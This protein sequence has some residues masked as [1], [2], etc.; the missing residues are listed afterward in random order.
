MKRFKQIRENINEISRSMTPMKNKFGAR[1]I[2]AKKMD[3]YK[4]FAKSKNIDD[5]SIR[6]AMANPNAGESKKMMKNKD[7][8]KAMKMYKDA[9][10]DESIDERDSQNA[11]KRKSMD[12]V[13]GARFKQQ[14]PNMVPARDPKKHKTTQQYNKAIGRA[15]RTQSVNAEANIKEYHH[16][17]AAK[18]RAKVAVRKTAEIRKR[19]AD[20]IK[21]GIRL[22]DYSKKQKQ[23][24]SY[25]PEDSDAVKAFLAKGG[26]IK[27]LPPAKAQGY[28][29]KDDPGQGM[30]GMMDKP[31]TKG[32]KK[33]KY[34]RSMK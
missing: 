29:G 33:D 10:L 17:D 8:A 6:M 14:N 26:K 15:L 1:N 2:D 4:K 5:S 9:S 27:K 20:E 34:V 24:N 13:R 16:D 22:P 31:D 28:H 19:H 3:A 18:A 21:K 32:F 30:H 12:A 23:N 7:F 11:M 25:Q